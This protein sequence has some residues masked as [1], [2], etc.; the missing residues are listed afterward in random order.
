MK[1]LRINGIE[2][3][4]QSLQRIV[5]PHVLIKAALSSR[6][7]ARCSQHLLTFYR[8]LHRCHPGLSAGTGS[9]LREKNCAYGEGNTPIAPRP[10][11]P[12]QSDEDRL[13]PSAS[14]LHKAVVE[15]MLPLLLNK[16][17][18]FPGS[19]LC[20]SILLSCK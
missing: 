12:H 7:S 4:F 8:L 3:F 15:I 20:A 17:N 2:M 16:K 5:L 6:T 13:L 10:I 9:G 1:S 18:G 19:S 11:V 14:P